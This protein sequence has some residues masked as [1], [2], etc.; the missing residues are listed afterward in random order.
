MEDRLL[1]TDILPMNWINTSDLVKD[2]L[3]VEEEAL[4][5]T[6]TIMDSA[7]DDTFSNVFPDLD[8]CTLFE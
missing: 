8:F 5:T 4:A 1:N 3:N 6:N 2:L 7:W